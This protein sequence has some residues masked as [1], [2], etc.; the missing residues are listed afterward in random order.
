MSS[1]KLFSAFAL[2]GLALASAS[3]AH[4]D[5]SSTQYTQAV[6]AYNNRTSPDSVTQGLQLLTQAET[7]VADDDAKYVLALT[8][9]NRLDVLLNPQCQRARRGRVVKHNHN[10][11]GAQ[12][13]GDF[14]MA[15]K[16]KGQWPQQP[17]LDQRRMTGQK[18]QGEPELF[19]VVDDQ[20]HHARLGGIE[21]AIEICVIIRFRIPESWALEEFGNQFAQGG[22]G[23]AGAEGRQ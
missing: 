21:L 10:A 8:I 22:R 16:A 18:F 7:T 12:E 17:L 15:D 23:F 13:R 11:F 5:D 4:A 1:S 9:R 20:D 6:T 19:L 3:L 2:G 14:G